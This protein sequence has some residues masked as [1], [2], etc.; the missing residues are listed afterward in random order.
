MKLMVMF[1]VSSYTIEYL[2]YIE[3]IIFIIFLG[4]IS[5]FFLA[6]IKAELNGWIY[7]KLIG[8]TLTLSILG[9]CLYIFIFI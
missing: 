7:E 4:E 2:N 5:V 1:V 6:I 3:H 9:G 8:F